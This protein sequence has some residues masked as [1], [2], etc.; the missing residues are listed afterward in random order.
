MQYLYVLVSSP[1]DIY[2]EQF[3]LS[4][5]SLKLLMP[6]ANVVLLCDSGTKENLIKKRSGHERL[7][8]QTIAVNVPVGMSQVE[9]SRWVKTSMCRHVSGDFLF[10]DCDT[11]ITNDLS[12]ISKA[13]IKFGACL[14][15]HSMIDRHSKGN[16]IIE[17]DKQL[18]FTSYLSNRHINSGVIF[19]ADTPE[20]HRL[21]D[22][23]HELWLFGNSKNTVRDQPSFNM[24]IY[25][26]SALF[27][28]MD[29]TWNCQISFNGLPFLSD[30]KIIH[31]FASDLVQHKSP[32]LLA[33]DDIFREIKETGTIPDKALGLLKNPRAAFASE[34]RIVTGEN[35]LHVLNS[36]IFE[37][38]LLLRQKTP[39]LFGVFNHLGF[40]GKKITKS[41]LVRSSKKK[42]GGTKYYN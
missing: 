34:V 18:G 5:T 20:T 3:F 29:G 40:L 25:E 24:A 4:V 15:K 39:S 7:V 10:I 21:F 38:L 11:I 26:N 1:G 42:D 35:I 22:R 23:W 2:Y 17:K 33:S 36:N 37:T 41:F 9:I 19:C 32:F 6:D 31:Y 14:D 27:T 8:S 30:S 16:S 13:E 12:S 28:E